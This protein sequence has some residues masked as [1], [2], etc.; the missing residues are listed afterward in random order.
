MFQDNIVGGHVRE[1]SIGMG[2]VFMDMLE[3][4]YVFVTCLLILV[5]LSMLF[6]FVKVSRSKCVVIGLLHAN[7]HFIATMALMVM[8]EIG[9]ETCVRHRLLGTYGIYPFV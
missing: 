1:F 8:L 3:H 2:H 4:N 6:V 5:A 7:V 9:L